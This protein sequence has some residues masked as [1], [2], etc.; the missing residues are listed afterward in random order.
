MKKEHGSFRFGGKNPQRPQPPPTAQISPSPKHHAVCRRANQRMNISYILSCV[1]IFLSVISISSSFAY[2][3]LRSSMS[4]NI[5]SSLRCSSRLK[6]SQ[7]PYF[8]SA[9]SRPRR[10]SPYFTS[11][12]A[13]A[14]DTVDMPVTPTRHESKR[15]DSGGGSKKS[16]SPNKRLKA[17]PPK[18]ERTQSFE[19]AWWGNVLVNRTQSTLVSKSSCQQELTTPTKTNYPPIHTLIVGTHPS[20]VSL[21]SNQFYGHP[22]NAFWYLVG[23]SM[24][25]R[26]CPAI[27][28]TT[29]KPYV[30][31][32]DHLRY[33]MDKIIDYDKQLETFVSKGFALWDIVQE[34]E[35]KGSLDTDIKVETPNPIREFCNERGSVKRIVIANGTTG[36]KFFVKHFKDW[37]TD[38]GLVAGEDEL[39]QRV[40][41][42]VMN[43]AKKMSAANVGEV[44][45]GDVIEVVCLPSVS[46][47]AAKFSYL[48][49]REL[50][51]KGC[52]EPGLADY[53]SW[54]NQTSIVTPTPLKRPANKSSTKPSSTKALEAQFVSSDLAKLSPDND[55]VDLC[56]SPE[57]LRASATLTNGQCFNWMVVDKASTGDSKQSA[58]G[59]HDAKEWVG[60][61]MNRVFSIKETP[62]TTLYRVLYGS[63]EGATDD[64]RVSAAIVLVFP[65][66]HA[67]AAADSKYLTISLNCLQQSYFRLE[68]PLAPLYK[69][70]SEADH[71]LAKIAT[72]I[73]G[74][75]ILRQDPIEC[76]FSFICSSN[77]N[78]PRITKMLTSFR[79]D[80]GDFMMKLPTQNGEEYSIYSFPTLDS[81]SSVTE[82]D[83]RAM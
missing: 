30:N 36:G 1:L 45:N 17:S 46:P 48:E 37:F 12:S 61:L 77:N 75:R 74:C 49:K 79:Q 3:I 80:Y 28:P 64:L 22:L 15:K 18:V 51:E 11:A 14:D 25:F 20:I 7:S 83:L 21:S 60:P 32:H 35:R 34:C 73:P 69:E 31:F 70:W 24:G 10:T 72:V 5:A 40:F 23:D 55:W 59:T 43:S 67:I 50:W 53:A 6:S 4:G 9:V 56:A 33:G 41:K 54:K 57:E 42:A 78:I 68:T 26:R 13:T 81:L 65:A 66:D 47:A 2:Q 71:R 8:N 82:Q 29:N 76:M 58:W 62:T 38:G 39:S 27:S 16:A 44:N 19:P 52:F 63:E